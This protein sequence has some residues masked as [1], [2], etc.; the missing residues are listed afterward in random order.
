YLGAA[1]ENSDQAFDPGGNRIPF[2]GRGAKQ[3]RA[4]AY[5]E[6][7]LSNATTLVVNAPYERVTSRGLFHDFTTT[8]AGDLDLRIR[9]SRVC[10]AGA[11]AVEGGAFIPLGYDVRAFPQLGSGSVEPIVNLA[12]SRS[13]AWLPSGFFSAQIGHRWRGEDL[14]NELPYSA[15]LG[16][17]PLSRVGTFVFVRGWES[18]GNFRATDPNFALIAADSERSS[19]GSEIYVRVTRT[20][21]MNATWSRAIGGRNTAA[22]D[23]YG[24]GFAVNLK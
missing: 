20:I 24:V 2:P 14:S 16:L 6:V 18:R 23:E 1:G 17:F 21:D 3:R 9:L 15:K 5:I 13:V 19:A 11:F 10:S 4:S 12:F 7:G 8:G 22:G